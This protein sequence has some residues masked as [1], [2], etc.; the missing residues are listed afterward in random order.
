MFSKNKKG[1]PSALERKI[2]F[3]RSYSKLWADLFTFYAD[4][5]DEAKISPQQEEE[6]FKIMSVLANRHFELTVR[7]GD[8]L[9]DGDKILEY[10]GKLVSLANLQTMSEAEFSSTQVRWHEIFIGLNKAMGGL[11]AQLPQTPPP[12]GAAASAGAKA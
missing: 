1:E 7:L 4:K 5:L 6:F 8:H 3:C 2:Q 12:K 11:V 9:K 10:L